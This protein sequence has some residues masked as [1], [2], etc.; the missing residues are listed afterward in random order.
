MTERSGFLPEPIED[1]SGGSSELLERAIRAHG[2][3]DR[4]RQ[5]NR[6][7]ASLSAGGTLW[8]AKGQACALEDATVTLDTHAQRCSLQP[9]GGNDQRAIFTPDRV[10]IETAD[11]RVVEERQNPRASFD[12]QL[13]APWDTLHLAYFAGCAMWTY[14][15]VPFLLA[16]PGFRVEELDPAEEDGEPRFTL[17]ARFPAEIASHCSEQIF[18]FG[19]DGLLR[20]H[21]YTPELLLGHP[22]HLA[23]A[24]YTDDHKPYGGIEFPT[25]RRAV[26]LRPDGET[27][28]EPAL[29][30]IEIKDVTIE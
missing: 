4:W 16:G 12:R 29:V 8:A 2:G 1:G 9:L 26:A 15:T 14:L 3:G 24:H 6:I 25:R 22:G 7:T 13:D 30:T 27:V 20:R 5:I 21:D 18:W 17:R 10:E 11:G 28:V 23:V 19:P